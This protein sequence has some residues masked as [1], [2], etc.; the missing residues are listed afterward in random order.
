[1][2]KR[3]LYLT[4]K[5]FFFSPTTLPR[6]DVSLT[7]TKRQ[8]LRHQVPKGQRLS[9][10]SKYDFSGFNI[11]FYEVSV[12]G[13]GEE[14]LGRERVGETKEVTTESRSRKG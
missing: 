4:T 8:R 1:M 9:R 14:S 5:S 6:H 7:V 10:I 13:L 3:Q 2:S 12:T 11:R